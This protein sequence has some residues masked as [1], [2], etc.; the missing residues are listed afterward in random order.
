M[1]G[2]RI[3]I[4]G[5]DGSGKSSIINMLQNRL[6]HLPVAFR[7]E[8]S[9]KYADI[10][11]DAMY[12]QNEMEIAM[13]FLADRAQHQ[14]TCRTLQDE[15]TTIIC[16]R[17]IHST[18]AYQMETLKPYHP[19]PLEWMTGVM[20]NWFD[21]PDVCILMA[22]DIDTAIER[23]QKRKDNP[24]PYE[25]REFLER[26]SSNYGYLYIMDYGV[27]DA[28]LLVDADRPLEDVYKDVEKIIRD[29]I[30]TTFRTPDHPF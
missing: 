1:R 8:P 20:N 19:Y 23:I 28:F 25:K 26:V 22:V 29:K 6:S 4:E 30:S 24:V 14:E 5:I 27:N 17:G 15:G 13:L 7:R 9:K 10:I 3:N 18:F 2:L 16:D 12:E 21:Y 11:H